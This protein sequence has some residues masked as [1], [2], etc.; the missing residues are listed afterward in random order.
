MPVRRHFENRRREI[1]GRSRLSPSLALATTAAALLIACAPARADECASLVD[2]FNRAVDAGLEGEAQHRVDEIATNPECARFQIPAQ[3]RLAALRLSSVQQLMARGRPTSEYEPL[4]SAAERTEVLW[5]ASATMGE[6][7]FGQRRFAEAA[8]AFDRAIEIIKDETRTPTAPS[9]FEIESLLD[10]AAQARILAANT[11]PAAGQRGFV[12]TAR[13]QRDGKLG[14]IYSPSV[15]GIVPRAIPV[16]ITFE[17]AKT[18]FT[19]IGEE[20][21]DELVTALKEQ[22]PSRIILVGHTDV[23]GTAEMNMKLS[24]ARADAVAAFLRERGLDIQVETIGKGSTEPMRLSDTS[25]LTQED[26]YALN[27]R[28]EWRRQ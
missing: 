6:V 1:A 18:T 13:D 11:A 27:R 12:K 5:Q 19:P 16:P 8:M 26:I 3:R 20:A 17:F 28:V 7:R 15:R 25:G 9:Q 21:A 23:R 14:G 10:R 24:E 4:L 22:R 2:G